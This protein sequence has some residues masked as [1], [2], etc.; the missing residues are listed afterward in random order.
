MLLRLINPYPARERSGPASTGLCECHIYSK[1]KALLIGVSEH[2]SRDHS[3]TKYCLGCNTP[4]R[5][6]SSKKKLEELKERHKCSLTYVE[7][8]DGNMFL[9]ESQEK[10]L[11]TYLRDTKTPRQYPRDDLLLQNWDK[12]N[13]SLGLPEVDATIMEGMFLKISPSSPAHPGA[14]MNLPRMAC[15]S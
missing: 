10:A 13:L 9:S 12:L 8:P 7:P 5:K 4:F 6:D 14:N 1:E 3:W 11:P 2:M 15:P